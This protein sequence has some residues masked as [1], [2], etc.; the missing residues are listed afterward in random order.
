MLCGELEWMPPTFRPLAP[1][2]VDAHDVHHAAFPLK[3]HFF[4]SSLV[5]ID[6]H[7]QVFDVGTLWQLAESFT[8]DAIFRHDT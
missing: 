6:Y 8:T 2:I 7:P 1:I 3:L 5:F 4:H